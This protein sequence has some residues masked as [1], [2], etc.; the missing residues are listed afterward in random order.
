MQIEL[1]LEILPKKDS[2]KTSY[3]MT[4]L[5]YSLSGYIW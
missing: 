4:F 2:E 3:K 1:L 5:N